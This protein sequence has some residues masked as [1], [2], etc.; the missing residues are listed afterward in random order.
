MEIYVKSNIQLQKKNNDLQN[1][2]DFNRNKEK[3]QKTKV[4]SLEKDLLFLQ[5]EIS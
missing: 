4:K 5:E 2:L 3:Q 1:A